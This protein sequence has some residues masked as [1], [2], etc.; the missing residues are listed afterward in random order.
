M[1]REEIEERLLDIGGLLLEA[2]LPTREIMDLW[3]E[4]ARLEKL[5]DD[6]EP[7]S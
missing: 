2:T 5:L 1:T 4:Q 3:E 7:A 6:M